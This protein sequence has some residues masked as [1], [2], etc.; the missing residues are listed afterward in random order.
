M[1]A[2]SDSTFGRVSMPSILTTAA[3][4]TSFSGLM[5]P[6]SE[7]LACLAS[8]L[9]PAIVQTNGIPQ[10]KGP[11]LRVVIRM[12]RNAYAWQRNTLCRSAQWLSVVLPISAANTRRNNRALLFFQLPKFSLAG[13]GTMDG[14]TPSKW[15]TAGRFKV[16]RLGV[17]ENV[18]PD[19]RSRRSLLSHAERT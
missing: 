13:G 5:G 19:S 12:S 16:I 2:C 10:T 17:Q 4:S 7:T 14:A 6:Q 1:G 3:H 9:G 18:N 8:L 11:C 15:Y